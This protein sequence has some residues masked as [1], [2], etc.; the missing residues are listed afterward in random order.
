[1]NIRRKQHRLAIYAAA[2]LLIWI[3]IA[4]FLAMVL[5]VERNIDRA[6]AILV[7]AGSTAFV[8]RTRTAAIIYK[9]GVAPLVLL[10][11]DGELAGWSQYEQRNRHY[12]DLSKRELVAQGVPVSDIEILVPEVSGTI[13]EAEVLCRLAVAR[14][15]ESLLIVTS[16]FHTRRALWAF[17]S[18]F[19]KNDVATMIGIVPAIS[20]QNTQSTFYWWLTWTGW[21]DVAGEYIKSA[22]YQFKY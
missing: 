9:R 3:F 7:L 10:T 8:A 17:E 6:D 12:V 16:G 11:N 1:M 20:E 21:R 4:P 15:W 14:R 22:Y 19:A 13:G 5:V 2:I 18:V